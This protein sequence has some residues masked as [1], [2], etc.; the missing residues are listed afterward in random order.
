MSNRIVLL[1]TIQQYNEYNSINDKNK[2]LTP[3]IIIAFD[4]ELRIL[5]NKQNK[6]YKVPEFYL[7]EENGEEIDNAA[8]FLADN[9]HKDLFKFNSVSLGLLVQMDLKYYF[10]GIIRSILTILNI[11]HNEN[12]L[13]IIAIDDSDLSIRDFNN[14]L[15]LICNKNKILVKIIP[16]RS[17]VESSK[18]NIR[19][20]MILLNKYV[21]I[22]SW[23]LFFKYGMEM[24]SNFVRSLK[25]FKLKLKNRNLKRILMI[26]AGYHNTILNKLE[27]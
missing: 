24:F 11:I 10:I 4:I 18:Y 12:P 14:L 7:S 17:S 13:E 22:A 15:N 25:Y 1:H 3:T 16:T 23:Y 21:R 8:I 2:D 20:Y 6:D 27:F 5:L 26:G 9:W 19:N